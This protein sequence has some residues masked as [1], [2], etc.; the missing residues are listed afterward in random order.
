MTDREPTTA[1]P[2]GRQL[3]I[4]FGEQVAT[5]VEVGGGIRRYADGG[6][7]V[8]DPYPVDQMCDGA[9]GAPLVPWP[10]RLADGSYHFDGTDH[11]VAL[12]EP[13]KH[14][15]IHGF[16]RWRSWDCVDHRD[17]RVTMA[18][19]LHPLPGYPFTLAVE[20]TYRLDRSGLTVTTS[21]TNVG[22]ATAPYGCGQHPYLSPGEGVVDDSVLRLAAGTRVVTDP[23]RKL[24]VGRESV[25]DTAYDFRE[26]R[27]IGALEL[28]DA[29]TD[30]DRDPDGR[31]WVHLTGSDGRTARLWVDEGYRFVELFTGDTLAPSRRRRG[32]GTEPMSCPPDAFRSGADVVRLAPGQRTTAS[33]GASLSPS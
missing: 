17:D 14:N 5:V 28:D 6:R 26:G 10:N 30:L 3:E 4:G 13:D 2:S 9:H 20:V 1:G 22:S 21:A 19:T 32:L 29:F 8:L 23:D 27:K 18:T 31:A 7:D 11:Q 25:R 12:T 16:L 33:W 15:A 24:P